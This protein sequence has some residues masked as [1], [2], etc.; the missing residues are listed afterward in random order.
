MSFL[1]A[2]PGI[3]QGA[4]FEFFIG[5][6]LF[7]VVAIIISIII[8]FREGIIK[9]QKEKRAELRDL[10]KKVARAF[11]T[12]KESERF[13]FYYEGYG[14]DI[15]DDLYAGI[16]LKQLLQIIIKKTGNADRSTSTQDEIKNQLIYWLREFAEENIIIYM[17]IGM[18]KWIKAVHKEEQT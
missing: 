12:L 9:D 13:V 7:G 16:Y 3:N 10:N 5:I 18:Q 14:I 1:D 6:F 2:I 4:F 17:R 15:T 11:Q 8:I